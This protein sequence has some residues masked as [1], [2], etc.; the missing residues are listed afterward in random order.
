MAI[1]SQSLLAVGLADKTVSMKIQ[2][3]LGGIT[4][5]VPHPRLD[6]KTMMLG[7]DVTHPPQRGF[8]G[9]IQPSIAVSVA[10]ISGTNNQVKEAIRLQRGGQYVKLYS[11]LAPTTLIYREIIEDMTNM[12]IGH[13]KTFHKN[14]KAYP[15]KI[16]MFRDGVSEGQYGQVVQ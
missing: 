15:E 14:T 13:L 3:K 5:T 7:A 6:N 16:I 4:H 10:T 8:G 9:P 1:V 12:V 2:A 11:A